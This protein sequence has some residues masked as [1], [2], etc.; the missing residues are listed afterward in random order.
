[1]AV[2]RGSFDLDERYRALSAAGDP[3]ERLAAVVD[4]EVFFGELA[5]RGYLAMGGQ[6]LD[7][8]ILDATVVEA[9]RPLAKERPRSR[10]AGVPKSWSK[11][12][13]AQMDKDGRWTLKRGRKK[14]APT[15]RRGRQRRL[16]CRPSATRTT[17]ASTGASA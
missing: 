6:I 13:R 9:R 8:T 14:P 15:G 17:S 12:K 16:S 4:F 5:D 10:V 2:Q 3:L 11:A 7:A 1:M